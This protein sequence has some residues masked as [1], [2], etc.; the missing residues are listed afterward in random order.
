MRKKVAIQSAVKLN[1]V[2]NDNKLISAMRNIK[3]MDS[4]ENPNAIRD[5]NFFLLTT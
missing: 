2:L 1:T 4:I 3:F 5:I